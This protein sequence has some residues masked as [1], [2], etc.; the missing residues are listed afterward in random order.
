MSGY[1]VDPRPSFLKATFD[2]APEH[3]HKNETLLLSGLVLEA[4]KGTASWKCKAEKNCA[5]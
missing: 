4:I 3:Y 1:F 2:K 5:L